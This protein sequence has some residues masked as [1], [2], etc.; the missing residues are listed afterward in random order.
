MNKA[1]S[2]YMR[3]IQ[4]CSAKSRWSGMTKEERS[5]AMSK[6][7]RAGVTNPS[8]KKQAKKPKR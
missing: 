3:L 1:V 6:V 5:A 4:S 2:D 8:L 7:R